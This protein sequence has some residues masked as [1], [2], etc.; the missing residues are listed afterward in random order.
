VKGPASDLHS[1]VFGG[2]VQNPAHALARL[3]AS[4]HHATG[5]V[6]VPGFYDHVVAQEAGVDF[7]EEAY[8]RSLGV[9][10]LFGEPG[11]TTLQRSWLRPTIEV[12]GLHAGQPGAGVQAIVPAEAAAQI[13]CRLVEGQQPDRILDLVEAHIRRAAP[14]GVTVTVRRLPGKARPYH[15]AADHPMNRAAADALAEVYGRAPLHVRMGATIPV[16]G[17]FRDL[18]GADTVLF[19][20]GLDDEN[21]HAPDEFFRLRSWDQGCRAYCLLLDKLRR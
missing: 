5:R 10:Q 15:M 14:P 1:G 7:D 18:L 4:L 21:I 6:A 13:T 19:A 3:V 2:T 20:F 8:R 11:F 17:L 12:N 9:P 16:C